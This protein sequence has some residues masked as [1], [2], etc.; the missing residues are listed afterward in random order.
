MSAYRITFFFC[1]F[2]CSFLVQA[3]P[4]ANS[5]GN[6]IHAS[7]SVVS[8]GFI[9]L[10]FDNYAQ[11]LPAREPVHIQVSSDAQFQNP[12]RDLTLT[13]QSQVHLSGF[14]D[15]NYFARVVS[16]AGQTIGRPAE[17]SVVHRDLTSA[18]LLFGLGAVLFFI[19][20]TCLIRFTRKNN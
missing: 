1:L 2:F 9:T 12:V 10:N 8:E 7:A 16:S 19:L 18:T 13:A 4:E 5:Q 3:E 15:G 6:V 20:I 14:N 17:F 11:S